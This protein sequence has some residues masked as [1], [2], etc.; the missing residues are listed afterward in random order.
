MTEK[1]ID[2]LILGGGLAGLSACY[3]GNGIV[4]E[5]DN[6]WGGHARSHSSDGFVFDE[7]IHVLHTDNEY[8]LNLLNEI[9]VELEVKERD[10]WIFSHGAM[11]RYPFQ[12]NTYGLPPDIV[13]EC[14]LGFIENKHK[15][16]DIKNYEDWVRYIFGDGIADNFMLPYSKKFWGVD[17]K[18]LTTDWVNVRHPRPSMEEVITGAISDQ[19]KGFGINATFRYPKQGGFGYIGEMLAESCKGRINSGMR[20]THI[21]LDRKSVIFNDH[22]EVNYQNLLSTIPLPEL[23]NII[24]DTPKEVL[25]ASEKLRTNSIYVVNLGVDRANITEKS[26]IYFLDKEFSFVRVSFPFNFT[27]SND[28]VVPSGCSSISVEIAYGNDNPLPLP[29]EDMAQRAIEDLKKANIILESDNIIYEHTYDI[30]Y[31][32]V[33]YDENKKESVKKIHE[34]LKPHSIFPCGRYGLWAYLWSDEAIMSGKVA[35]EKL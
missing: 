33:V 10:A 4:F 7:G 35:A 14:L 18:N 15:K 28:S 23:L 31:G 34:F 11:T 30:K 17:P 5:K 25:K 6:S 29:K 32:Y 9:D 12:A 26:W 24:P 13:K 2:T 16:G 20:A 1:K 19:K 21:D 8:I 22:D 3:H 27:H